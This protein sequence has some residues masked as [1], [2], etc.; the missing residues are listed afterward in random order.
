MHL[1]VCRA[2]LLVLVLSSTCDAGQSKLANIQVQAGRTFLY[3]VSSDVLQPSKSSSDVNYSIISTDGSPLPAWVAFN[4]SDR[5]LSGQPPTGR[6][7][8]LNWTLSASDG[9]DTTAADTFLFISAAP[10]PSGLYRHFRIRITVTDNASEDAGPSVDKAALCTASWELS[11]AAKPAFP[12]AGQ[13][14]Y[15]ISGNDQSSAHVSSSPLRAFQ[16]LS[17]EA[18]TSSSAWLVGDLPA[19]ATLAVGLGNGTNHGWLAAKAKGRIASLSRLIL[20]AQRCRQCACLNNAYL[21]IL[22][23]LTQSA[24]KEMGALSFPLCYWQSTRAFGPTCHK[25]VGALQ[26]HPG[27]S[28]ALDLGYGGCEAWPAR[29]LLSAPMAGAHMPSSFTADASGAALQ[30]GAASP[31]W[32]NLLTVQ[33]F[34]PA[35]PSGE[36]CTEGATQPGCGTFTY[37]FSIAQPAVQSN[38]PPRALS[39][40]P[41]TVV[42]IGS[43]NDTLIDVSS[44]FGGDSRVCC[45]ELTLSIVASTPY[46][47]SFLAPALAP[48]PLAQLPSYMPLL[49]INVAHEPFPDAS[50]HS[51]A[52]PL[53]SSPADSPS[54]PAWSAVGSYDEPQLAPS[55][56]NQISA[57]LLPI[58]SSQLPNTDANVPLA[59]APAY[60]QAP[61]LP[62]SAPGS[63]LPPD[64]SWAA[65]TSPLSLPPSPMPYYP[66]SLVLQGSLGAAPPAP[67]S[68]PLLQLSPELTPLESFSAPTSSPTAPSMSFPPHLSWSLPGD[69]APALAPASSP[70]T[71]LPL[72]SHAPLLSPFSED[73]HPHLATLPPHPGPGPAPG[74]GIATSPSRSTTAQGPFPHGSSAAPSVSTHEIAPAL[75]QPEIP[76]PS[77]PVADLAPAP[78]ADSIVPL[79]RP[80]PAAPYEAPLSRFTDGT[81]ALHV[82]PAAFSP[83]LPYSTTSA[84][85]PIWPGA[86]STDVLPSMAPLLYA[87]SAAQAPAPIAAASSPSLM[88]MT[89]SHQLT[90]ADAPPL[91]HIPAASA[92]LPAD[93]APPGADLPAVPALLE[94][95]LLPTPAASHCPN[96]I[97]ALPEVH[98]P[99]HHAHA[100]PR[101]SHASLSPLPTLNADPPPPVTLM[102][103]MQ[104]TWVPQPS[105]L[106]LPPVMTLSGFTTPG[107]VP[108]PMPAVST[109][110]PISAQQYAPAPSLTF[111]ETPELLPPFESQQAVML[112]FARLPQPAAPLIDTVH[113]FPAPDDAP[114]SSRPAVMQPAM[115]PL[116]PMNAPSPLIDAP[117]KFGIPVPFDLSALP[118]PDQPAV[119][120]SAPYITVQPSVLEPPTSIPGHGAYM[121][122]MAPHPVPVDVPIASGPAAAP[123]IT[124]TPYVYDPPA[125]IPGHAAHI[126]TTA[127]H[128]VHVE[129]P[130]IPATVSNAPHGLPLS[131]APDMPLP[132]ATNDPLIPSSSQANAAD[133]V[134]FDAA[135]VSGPASDPRQLMHSP[136]PY[137]APAAVAPSGPSQ[138]VAVSASAAESPAFPRLMPSHP[139]SSLTP[140]SAPQPPSPS[141]YAA[142]PAVS[143]ANPTAIGT[144]LAPLHA[145]S[146]S[147]GSDA[148]PA[149]YDFPSKLPPSDDPFNLSPPDS[150]YTL[151]G[152]LTPASLDHD[153]APLPISAPAPGHLHSPLSSA[154]PNIFMNAPHSAHPSQSLTA[155]QT[156][157]D[158]LE[159]MSTNAVPVQLP[160]Y[161]PSPLKQLPPVASYG[162]SPFDP[163]FASL[164]PHLHDATGLMLAPQP[165]ERAAT[166]PYLQSVPLSEHPLYSLSPAPALQPSPPPSYAATPTLAD[167]DKPVAISTPSAPSYG[168]LP[169]PVSNVIPADN[170]FPSMLPLQDEA[171]IMSPPDSQYILPAWFTPAS[172][173]HDP[174]PMPITAPAHGYLSSPPSS[175]MPNI[176]MDTP[177][178][179]QPSRGLTAVHA[180]TDSL[181]RASVN[182]VPVQ[183]PSSLELPLAAPHGMSPLD[184]AFSGLAQHLHDSIEF[185]PAQPMERVANVP[186]L[187][188]LPLHEHLSRSSEGPSIS[189]FIG[190]ATLEPQFYEL[191]ARAAGSFPAPASSFLPA[192]YF[193]PS[194]PD[195]HQQAPLEGGSFGFPASQRMTLPSIPSSSIPAYS[196]T[197]TSYSN[198]PASN[199][200]PAVAPLVFIA[201]IPLPHG[202]DIPAAISPMQPSQQV[203]PGPHPSPHPYAPSPAPGE[204][205]P[206]GIPSMHFGKDSISL[207]T[208]RSAFSVPDLIFPA[209]LHSESVSPSSPHLA[210]DPYN[211]LLSPDSPSHSQWAALDVAPDPD[212]SSSPAIKAPASLTPPLDLAPQSELDDA[213]SAASP[214]LWP[215]QTPWLGV[216]NPA[217]LPRLNLQDHSPIADVLSVSAGPPALDTKGYA[218]SPA[219]LLA[220]HNPWP[221]NDNTPANPAPSQDLQYVSNGLPKL[222][223]FPQAQVPHPTSAP[224][225]APTS[226][227]P[228]WTYDSYFDLPVPASPRSAPSAA[229]AFWSYGQATPASSSPSQAIWA[230]MPSPNALPDPYAPI[231]LPSSVA[232]SPNM[233]DL[234]SAAQSGPAPTLP[235]STSASFADIPIAASSDPEVAFN[236]GSHGQ[237]ALVSSSPYQPIQA[238]WAGMPNLIAVSNPYMPD[239]NLDASVDP[240]PALFSPSMVNQHHMPLT[241]SSGSLAPTLDP[242]TPS[243]GT[244]PEPMPWIAADLALIPSSSPPESS[245]L[246]PYVPGYPRPASGHPGSIN[247]SMDITHP[248]SLPLT[249]PDLPTSSLGSPS[250]ASPAP[251]SWYNVQSAASPSSRRLLLDQAL[252]TDLSAPQTSVALAPPQSSDTIAGSHQ[253]LSQPSSLPAWLSLTFGVMPDASTDHYT[254]LHYV[255]IS[256]SVP[257]SAAGTYLLQLSARLPDSNATAVSQFRLSIIPASNKGRVIPGAS[258]LD[259]LSHM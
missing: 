195:Q 43:P 18:C 123:Y 205:F 49:P 79:H 77:P 256:R 118:F 109:V 194:L 39:A 113:P 169:S 126:P 151:P 184:P 66:D 154:M 52:L 88:P 202:H 68:Q 12:S 188:A 226:S 138:A 159:Q 237:A 251:S 19:S 29:L 180:N 70:S 250:M 48:D 207:S 75:L 98:A 239:I 112:P 193:P 200:L 54:N 176:F 13:P 211:A 45:L 94:P 64:M 27:D 157:T 53:G 85:S 99:V 16:Q 191:D 173:D 227:L 153:P 196:T 14:V 31:D 89:P 124:G 120:A 213:M 71:F 165:M 100:T 25:S 56:A 162:M 97:T 142:I 201:D 168:S 117:L 96:C 216:P 95:T 242:G 129:V 245:L 220:D 119:S 76:Y 24:T 57:S 186:N 171:L 241:A 221:A 210:P 44:V 132:L 63:S 152:Q 141:L 243:P 115:L 170:G 164:A 28:I 155:V 51:D 234:A 139:R 21:P 125:S 72:F 4:G 6:D 174:A 17:G 236:P 83:T 42:E 32:T 240:P 78:F 148:I 238:S 204:H 69:S 84:P 183:L 167:A 232:E 160:S 8:T 61:S 7:L 199:F 136:M 158:R 229:S 253:Q 67:F 92:P 93:E 150:L 233:P 214:S 111:T 87:P 1:D 34:Q 33:D 15:N 163:A 103:A 149:D 65:S 231:G 144:P 128:S 185:M 80:Q 108:E 107:P 58:P 59:P 3:Q 255:N 102:P 11:S 40:I 209:P 127:P 177:H 101:D 81:P 41:D 26:G 133:S 110:F 30:P 50:P 249:I 192:L 2:V 252:P 212:I 36:P 137:L 223:S 182:T 91:L 37:A 257:S 135:P 46:P 106:P 246:L 219:Y 203:W 146:T 254:A 222:V 145:S 104:P 74:E 62:S 5:T 131:F 38:A 73:L 10:C 208:G 247:P 130:V 189:T 181:D 235:T 55:P 121:P 122:N 9:P 156:G 225:S 178:S 20:A 217:L 172:L 224:A 143:A 179:A 198:V 244:L 197:S 22:F 187:Q 86:L 259:L 35:Y 23:A 82:P 248:T 114:T 60:V 166:V 161:L 147:P 47:G 218:P 175:G 230:G 134:I 140:A 215:P 228:L 105:D 190:P 206:Q 116:M 258:L 90:P